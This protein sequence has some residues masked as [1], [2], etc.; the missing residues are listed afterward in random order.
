MLHSLRANLH[1]DKSVFKVFLKYFSTHVTDTLNGNEHPYMPLS[2]QRQSRVYLYV[3]LPPKNVSIIRI[4]VTSANTTA[5][6]DSNTH[7]TNHKENAHN[8]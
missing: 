5:N 2:L 3:T 8:K 4:P 1:V 6:K 7:R